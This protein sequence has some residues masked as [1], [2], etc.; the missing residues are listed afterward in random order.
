MNNIGK[1][2]RETQ[3]RVLALFLAAGHPALRGRLSQMRRSARRLGPRPL[4]GLPA[5]AVCGIFLQA[6][7]HLPLLP[8]E[9]RPADRAARGRRGL[10]ALRAPASGLDDPQASATARPLRSPAA[11]PAPRVRRDVPPGRSSTPA[12]PGGRGDRHGRRDPDARD[13]AAA[14]SRRSDTPTRLREPANPC[15]FQQLVMCWTRRET[16]VYGALGCPR[17]PSVS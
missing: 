15:V 17:N 14:N 13:S 5:R 9:M 2:E 11:G 8:P 10:R 3:N 4:P 6:A 7:M 16:A 12:R 1:P